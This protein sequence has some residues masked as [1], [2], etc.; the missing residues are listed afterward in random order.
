M[1]STKKPAEEQHFVQVIDD[2]WAVYFKNTVQK[3]SHWDR[4]KKTLLK[5]LFLKFPLCFLAPLYTHCTKS[6]L[7]WEYM[8]IYFDVYFKSGEI[9]IKGHWEN[10]SLPVEAK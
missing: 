2:T 7:R 3:C 10:L 8:E 1:V 6:D 5:V 4:M 9:M